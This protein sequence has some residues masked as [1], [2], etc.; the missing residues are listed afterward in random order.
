MKSIYNHSPDVL[1]K[2]LNPFPFTFVESVICKQHGVIHV[3]SSFIYGIS[4]TNM[5][6]LSFVICLS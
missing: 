6:V 2:A 3:T 5:N 1:L 4:I